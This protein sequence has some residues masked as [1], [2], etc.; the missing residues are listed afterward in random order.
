[1]PSGIGVF[2]LPFGPFT[3]S[4][5]SPIV[6]E[7]PLGNVIAFLPMRDIVYLKDEGGTMKDEIVCFISI[8]STLSFILHP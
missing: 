3:S 2:K 7:T 4:A 6:T 8:A 5:C 1:M